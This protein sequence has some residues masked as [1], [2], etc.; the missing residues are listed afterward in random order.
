MDDGATVTFTDG[1]VT[2]MREGVH[3]R[4]EPRNRATTV[5]LP[6]SCF[7]LPVLDFALISHTC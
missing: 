3:G 7:R 4:S 6:S 2:P 1:V 5:L